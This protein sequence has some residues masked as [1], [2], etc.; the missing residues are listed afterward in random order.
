MRS[1]L[2]TE[3]RRKPTLVLQ[4]PSSQQADH[5]TVNTRFHES[6]TCLTNFGELRYSPNCIC[7]LDTGRYEWQTIPST[8]LP[9]KLVRTSIS[10]CCS[11]DS[12]MHRQPFK[13]K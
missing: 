8:K 2:H 9:S 4:L 10:N 7:G 1:S 5:K 13:S 6:M 11:T 12:P 3:T